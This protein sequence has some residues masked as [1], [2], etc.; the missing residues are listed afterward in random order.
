MSRK[1]PTLKPDVP[2]EQPKAVPAGWVELQDEL[3]RSSGLSL[4]LVGGHQPPALAIS[5]NN[6]ICHTLQTSPEHVKLCD[7]YC[8]IAHLRAVSA[9]AP[10]HYKCHAGLHCV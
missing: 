10:V 4:L 7:S 8:G 3:A 6:S 2:Q 5:N 1:S 9:A